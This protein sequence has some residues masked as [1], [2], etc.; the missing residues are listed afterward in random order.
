VIVPVYDVDGIKL[1]L[2]DCEA[3]MPTLLA[4]VDAVMAD[5]PYATTQND[6]DR[7]IDPK[8]LW[9]C[10][11]SLCGER[12]PILL[13]G[14]GLFTARMMS[15]NEADWK[16]NLVWDKQATSGPL[17]A[18]RQPLRAHEDIL[19]FYRRQPFYDPQMVF[20]GR[21]SHSR[22]STVERTVN[23]YNDFDNT[24]VVDQGGFQYPRSILAFK[25]PKLPKGMGHPTQKPVALM[26]W[27][28][29]SYTAPDALILDNVAGSASTLVAARNCGRR[30]IGIEK[31]EPYIEAAIRRLES[32]AEG[33]RW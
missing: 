23:H 11:R 9:H 6:W 13:F 2:G 28:V 25:R 5:L 30:A 29:R 22:G 1:Y 8:I 26:E 20:T 4:T 16:Y 14:S 3:I 21:S 12:T 27:M 19:V 32:G 10:Y 18:K 15:S 31:H 7:P 17:N 24:P 33:D